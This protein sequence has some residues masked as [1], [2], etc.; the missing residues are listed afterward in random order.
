MK[1]SHAANTH[2]SPAAPLWRGAAEA[3][4]IALLCAALL[5]TLAAAV[6]LRQ[7]DPTGPSAPLSLGVLYTSAALCG[8]LA[9][10]LCG[11]PLRG[12]AAAGGMFFLATAL[13]SLL[14]FGTR[15]DGFPLPVSLLLRLVAALTV[16][17]FSAL[18]GRRRRT[19]S[20]HK[21]R[22]R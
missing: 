1:D 4:G 19:P 20:R 15:G 17:V 9:A 21:K 12:G 5:L 6:L 11:E 3:A 10:R 16:F 22:T 8:L 13:L 14:P 7:A 18:A 2:R